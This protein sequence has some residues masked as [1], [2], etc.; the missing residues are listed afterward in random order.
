MAFEEAT[1]GDGGVSITGCTA[2][3]ATV[4][5]ML[6]MEVDDSENSDGEEDEE[7]E[8][9]EGEKSHLET[10]KLDGWWKMKAPPGAVVPALLLL[11]L[12]CR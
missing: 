3:P 11:T 1:R 7:Q 8:G 9:E 10:V 4:L 5:A 12:R 6:A 2:V